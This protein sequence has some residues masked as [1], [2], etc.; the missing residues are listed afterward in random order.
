MS[1]GFLLANIDVGLLTDPKLLRLGELVP[2]EGERACTI[3]VYLQTVLQSWHDGQ[4][5]T[6]EEAEGSGSPPLSASSALAAMAHRRRAPRSQ[7]G[8]EHYYVPALERSQRRSRAGPSGRPCQR[9]EAQARSSD[10][11]APPERS[12]RD[13]AAPPD[14]TPADTPSP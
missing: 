7:L 4:R 8:V 5:L 3:V 12:R 10:A 11:S 6:V 1:Q 13:A 14:L 9:Q 2:D